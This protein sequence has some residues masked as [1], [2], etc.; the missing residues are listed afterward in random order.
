MPLLY[1]PLLLLFYSHPQHL[2]LWPV[3]AGHRY[4]ALGFCRYLSA[5]MTLLLTSCW[6]FDMFFLVES[7]IHFS[8]TQFLLAL[9]YL[10]F[11]NWSEVKRAR[12]VLKVAWRWFCLPGGGNRMFSLALTSPAAQQGAICT[13]YFCGL[14]SPCACLMWVVWLCVRACVL[15]RRV[16]WQT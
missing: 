7:C 2:C 11:R 3:G 12:S 4:Q 16:N 5:A 10:H 15:Y 13:H 14:F 6:W 1:S 9:F 8:I